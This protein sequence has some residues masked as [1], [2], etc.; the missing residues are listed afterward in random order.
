MTQ[1]HL[2]PVRTH[3]RYIESRELSFTMIDRLVSN[4]EGSEIET[5]AR[6]PQ[7]SAEGLVYSLCGETRTCRL[8]KGTWVSDGALNDPSREEWKLT[9]MPNYVIW[10]SPM[11][12]PV[13]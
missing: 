11:K 9:E 7:A 4:H 8:R 12:C 1:I 13:L 6:A 5:K 3:A 2:F 10:P